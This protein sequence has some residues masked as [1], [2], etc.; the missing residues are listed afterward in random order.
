MGA[1]TIGFA[2]FPFAKRSEFAAQSLPSSLRQYNRVDAWIQVLEDGRVR[3]LTGKIE[4]GQGI[5]VAIAQVAAEELNADP[6]Q[7]EVRLAE[8]D[9]TPNEGYT[10]GSRS[11]E[12][13]A[14]SVRYAAAVAGDILLQRA[15]D[16]LNI[17]KDRL[18]LENGSV[19]SADGRSK[20]DF[21]TILDGQQIS[22]TVDR[23]VKLKRGDQRR[24]IGKPVPRNDI[25]GMVRGEG[26]YVQDLRFP[27]MVHAR[28]VRPPRYGA[29]LASVDE[30]ALR[31]S[32]PGVIAVVVRGSFVGVIA[33]E[34]YQA[35]RAMFS[36][37][38][39]CQ[40]SEAP[41]L[42][43]N[44][45]LKEYL[46]GLSSEVEVVESAAVDF[47]NGS[48]KASYF[49]PYVM[50]G[51]IGP[52]CAVARFADEQ[53]QV[54]THSQG[55][56]PLRASLAALVEMP[57]GR[58]RVTG[59]PGSGCYG[60]NGADDV[61]GDAAL[62]AIAHPGKPI[63]LQWSRD[64][65]H[66]WEPYGSA[67]IMELEASLDDFGM[68]DQWRY[69]LWSDTHSV[70][71]SG[72][73]ANLLAA[74][75]LENPY[76]PPAGGY[77]GG[78][79]RN[80][81]PAYAI[82]KVAI[83]ANRFRGPLRVSALRSLG[84]Y[85]NVF[86]IESFMDELAEEAGKNPVA[87]RLEHLADS[88]SR[89][90]LEKVEEMASRAEVGSGEG[91][92]FGFSQYKNSAAYCA[93][94][95]KVGLDEGGE[96]RVK[97]M[98]AAIDA[99]ETINPDGLKNQ[100]E[101]GMIQSASWTVKERVRFDENGIVSR[102]WGSYPILEF[103]DVPEVEVA[104]IDRPDKPPLGAGEAAQ[105]PAAAAIANALYRSS[106]RRIRDLPLIQRRAET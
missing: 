27:D 49:K 77:F 69:E 36:L 16:K 30:S 48:V 66:A 13:S 98:W 65:E 72:D 52:S 94:A 73:A 29:R 24:W 5:R 32:V 99:G 76:D 18:A 103:G 7:V 3:V 88:R 90:V 12:Q 55:V 57:S 26:A 96:P 33:E 95:A 9:V 43:A 41:R 87:F 37:R 6:A 4:L 15:A 62:L 20:M 86:A 40:W 14:M 19:V 97:R 56:Y 35:E 84:A 1:V 83:T 91:I 28:V 93:V 89:A 79:Y 51:S 104:I 54:W 45:P 63:R 23:P 2:L 34:E 80:S 100:T 10:A 67:M 101:G 21:A 50:H 75:Y 85:A 31:E 92:G 25:E 71:P 8:T 61:A 68:I 53:L 102:D 60:H 46:K 22:D 70:R 78:A 11:I 59:V 38:S 47:S 106:G 82:P 105:S 44:R 81:Q 39:N 42:P 64:D 17:P 74:Q 58:I